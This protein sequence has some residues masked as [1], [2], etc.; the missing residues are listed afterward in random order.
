MKSYF[1]ALTCIASYRIVSQVVAEKQGEAEASLNEIEQT[2]KDASE[3]KSEMEK[4]KVKAAEESQ[5]EME[6]EVAEAVT[7]GSPAGRRRT[8]SLGE[9]RALRAPP[10]VIRDIVEGVLRIMGVFHTSWGSM[11][12]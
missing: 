2:M 8:E 12:R 7:E 9:I 6:Q 11:K 4:L 3:S 5:K 1:I 10:D